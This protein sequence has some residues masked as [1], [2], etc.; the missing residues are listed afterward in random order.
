MINNLYSNDKQLTGIYR[1]FIVQSNNAEATVYIPALHRDQCPFSTCGVV[2]PPTS[3]TNPAGKSL[4]L[5]QSDY[6]TAQLSSWRCRPELHSGDAVL[7]SFEN[8]DSNY[9]V[10][11]GYLGDVLP[12]Y[13]GP[14]MFG[15]SGAP[16]QGGYSSDSGSGAANATGPCLIIAGHGKGDPG[17]CGNG[18]EEAT[19]TRE[20]VKMVSDKIGDRLSH[21][22]VVGENQNEYIDRAYDFTKFAYVLEVHFN[23]GGGNGAEILLHSSIS[24]NNLDTEILN[25]VLSTGIGKHGSG[26]VPRSD[27]GNMN[28]AKAGNVRYSLLE[29]CFID[30]ASDI[31]KYQSVKSKIASNIA[32]AL[33]KHLKQYE[34]QY[35]EGSGEGSVN[36]A[37]P[38]M[39]NAVATY[40][41]MITYLHNVNPG[42]PDY[43]KIYLTEGAAE[44]VRGDI[45]FAQSCC[46]TG[47]WRFGNDVK[48]SQNNF[49]G[50]GATGGGNPGNSFATPQI[51]IRAQIQHLKAYASTQPL[52]NQ[53]VDPRFNYVIRGSATTIGALSGK[54]AVATSYNNSIVGILNKILQQPK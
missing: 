52:N 5:K 31:Q 44:G 49:A 47:H 8:G 50:I 54:W 23:S 22:I 12:V 16:G 46:E 17:A 41:Q 45:A 9:P 21:T 38:I 30:S 53:C 39:G 43:V 3:S 19:L 26:Y 37:T 6:P 51:G 2:N 20:L 35:T 11:V 40:K 25:S 24:A 36:D 14:G 7:V 34:A 15:S 28:R 27:L 29:V 18:Y 4:I 32:D 10:I 13:T 33:V 42:A 48:A 1:A